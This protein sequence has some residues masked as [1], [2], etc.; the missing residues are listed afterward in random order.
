MSLEYDI[1]LKIGKKAEAQL[2][3]LEKK[4]VDKLYDNFI[5]PIRRGYL[6]EHLAGKYKPSWEIPEANTNFLCRGLADFAKK[7]SLYHYH[8]GYPFYESGQDLDYPGKTSDAIVHTIFT[9]QKSITKITESHSI[10]HIDPSHYH[11]FRVQTNIF[12]DFITIPPTTD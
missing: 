7:N 3:E 5:G 11:P 10:Y 9:Q 12:Q 2:R 6:K 1:S 4:I 8:F